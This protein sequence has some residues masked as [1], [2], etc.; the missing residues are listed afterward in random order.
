MISTIRDESRGQSGEMAKLSETLSRLDSETQDT[1]G[2]SEEMAA[3]G[4]RLRGHARELLGEMGAFS[5]GSDASSD[6]RRRA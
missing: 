2:L 3:M 5:L 4:L 1:A 6:Q